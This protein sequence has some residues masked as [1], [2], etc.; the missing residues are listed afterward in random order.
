MPDEDGALANIREKYQKVS[1][2]LVGT[3]VKKIVRVAISLR[4]VS[5]AAINGING[6]ALVKKRPT[7]TVNICLK[8]KLIKI[9]KDDRAETKRLQGVVQ[10]IMVISVKDLGC[11]AA[12]CQL[13]ATPKIR[14]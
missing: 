13:A 8:Q 1:R 12:G 4:P 3:S 6:F 7:K 10:V 5:P 11:S 14:L 2:F 9:M